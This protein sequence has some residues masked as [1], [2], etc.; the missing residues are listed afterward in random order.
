MSFVGRSVPRLEDKPLVTGGGRFAADV[1]FPHMLHMRLVRS[2]FAHGRIVVDRY[3]RGARAAGRGRGLDFC[4]RRRHSADRFSARPASR[5]WRLIA[6][7]SWRGSACAM[8]ASRLRPCS[9]PTPMWRRTQPTS[10]MSRSMSCRSFSMPAQRPA[11]SMTAV[12]PSRRSWR[13]RTAT[14]PRRSATPMRW[15]SSTSQIGRH[16]GVPMETRGAIA[17]YDAASDVLEMHGAAK[18]PHWNRDNIARM[19]GRDPSTVHLIEGHVGGG[20]GIRGELY[21]EDVLVC[22]CRAAA[23]PAGEMDRGSA[24]APDRRQPFAPA[25]AQGAR[26]SRQGRPHSRHRRRILPRPGRLCAHPCGDGARSRGR[27]AAGSLS[28][29]GLSGAR[30]CAAHQQDA[31]R[32][33][34]RAG[35]LREHVRARAA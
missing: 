16:S 8:S 7:P 32:H 24:R 13:N 26:R 15:S 31:G 33:L 14:L 17:R 22:A 2:G 25:A 21:P 20:F 34:S 9:R 35:P 30:A 3:G 12:R 5:A 11:S 10:S 23:R 4:R 28:G 29:A 18:V 1:A 19:L 27:H 6:R